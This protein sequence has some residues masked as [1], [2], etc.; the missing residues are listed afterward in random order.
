MQVGVSLCVC[1]YVSSS[2]SVSACLHHCLRLQLC[3]RLSMCL[4]LYVLVSACLC[5]SRMWVLSVCLAESLC[6][7]LVSVSA[8]VCVCVSVRPSVRLALFVPACVCVYLF[9]SVSVWKSCTIKKAKAPSNPDGGT[10][11]QHR[12]AAFVAKWLQLLNLFSA[13]FAPLPLA[14]QTLSV[15]AALLEVGLVTNASGW[16]RIGRDSCQQTL[17]SEYEQKFQAPMKDSTRVRSAR[18][19][20]VGTSSGELYAARKNHVRG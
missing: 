9:Q 14:V 18:L 19:A 8:C 15:Q 5:L 2:S 7:S 4:A 3:V 20:Y 13:H 17:G 6:L 10:V 1:V 16:H 12:S 11:R